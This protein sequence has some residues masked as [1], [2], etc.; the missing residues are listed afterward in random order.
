VHYGEGAAVTNGWKV[1]LRETPEGIDYLP[2]QGGEMAM[3]VG[4][5]GELI[6]WEINQQRANE[7]AAWAPVKKLRCAFSPGSWTY[8]KPPELWTP[9][10]S[11]A[12]N[13]CDCTCADMCPLGRTGLTVRC[14][15]QELRLALLDAYASLDRFMDGAKFKPGD[16]VSWLSRDDPPVTQTG[17]LEKMISPPSDAPIW[18]LHQDGNA[19]ATASYISST[20]LRKL[21]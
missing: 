21:T 2:I 13:G 9:P 5:A 11:P 7:Y 15:A 1:G 10:Q 19:P 17:T 16:R 8:C 12:L 6:I 3:E 18:Q 4:A 14:T 20:R